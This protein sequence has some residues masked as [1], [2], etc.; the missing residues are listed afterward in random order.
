M[1]GPQ[2]LISFEQAF[3]EFASDVGFVDDAK[4]VFLTA[5]MRALSTRASGNR[6]PRHVAVEVFAADS[7]A[8]DLALDRQY[9]HIVAMLQ[10]ANALQTKATA[11][12]RKLHPHT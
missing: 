8:M 4:N 12:L 7:E 10:R 2:D 1:D 9:A 6:L 3:Q 5:W 11:L